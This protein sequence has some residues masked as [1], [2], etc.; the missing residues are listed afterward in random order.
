[1]NGTVEIEAPDGTSAT[2]ALQGAEPVSWR[3]GG[4]EYL[5]SGDPDHWNRHAPWLFP[6]VGASA[7]GIVKVDGRDYPMGQHGF[8]RD[9]PFAIV[10]QRPD[11]VTLRLEDGPE[12]R[13]HYPFAF[14]LDIEASV[15]VGGLDFAVRVGNTGTV[16]LPYALGFH[17]A[18]PWPFAGGERKAGGGYAVV[19]ETP[20]RASVPEIAPGGL[21]A[22][23]ERRIPMEGDR[24]PLDPDIFKEA[25]VFL[26]A[27]S[28][29]FRFEAPGG[30]AILMEM[31]EFPH[32]AV[33]TKPT[34]P[35]LSLEC[36]TG[37]ADR[38]G[39]S[40]ALSARASQRLLAPGASA[41]HGVRVSLKG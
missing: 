28:R 14:R 13:R 25:L 38:A 41:A 31:E 39:F 21:I 23:E 34:A 3:V 30:E 10:A 24:L 29:S 12:T 36:W 9:L 33:W 18:Y 40:G 4:T 19:F 6:V 20:E 7:G 26:D 16:P 17:P 5:W 11:A 8:A 1:M 15:R 37:Y 27:N 22:A 32:L 2:I 35:F